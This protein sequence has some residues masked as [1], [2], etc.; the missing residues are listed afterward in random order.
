MT[1]TP[2]SAT[3]DSDDVAWLKDRALII[4]L[5]FQFA[6]ALDSKDWQ[7][8]ADLYAHDGVLSLPWGEV[9]T[10]E[11]LAA[12]TENNL[13]K[14]KATHHMSTNQ[15]VFLDGDTATSVSYTQATHVFPPELN[16]EH[17]VG[18]V[19][20][21]CSFRREDGVWKFTRVTLNPIWTTGQTT[22]RD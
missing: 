11:G 2:T 3:A 13:S 17:F 19:R 18:G 10:K 14:F 21:D 8:Y 4:D 1:T 5:L 22:P 12:S 6:T 20:Y 16:R 15:Q 7:G 9:V